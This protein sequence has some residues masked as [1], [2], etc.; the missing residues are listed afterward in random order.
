VVGEVTDGDD[1][2][3]VNDPEGFPAVGEG[4]AELVRQ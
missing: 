3:S 2:F 4:A 1:K